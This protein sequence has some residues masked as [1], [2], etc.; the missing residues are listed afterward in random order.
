MLSSIIIF[1]QRQQPPT[2]TM[3]DGRVHQSQRSGRCDCDR[4]WNI[5]LAEDGRP[6]RKQTA[7]DANKFD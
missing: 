1:S 5:H 2:T 4:D 7:G 3:T 6:L